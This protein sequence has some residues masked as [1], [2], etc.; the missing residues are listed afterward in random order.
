MFK[1]NN[2]DFKTTSMM[3]FWCLYF[4]PILHRFS[5]VSTVD[6]EYVFVCWFTGKH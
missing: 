4:A 5:G 6:F 3:S 2:K 1:V